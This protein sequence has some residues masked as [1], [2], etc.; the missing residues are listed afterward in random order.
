[1]QKPS[2]IPQPV[3]DSEEDFMN[4]S[5]DK[6]YKPRVSARAKR[7]RVVTP[8]V[9]AAV[10]WAKISS[11]KAV[12]VIGSALIS[13]GHDLNDCALSRMTMHRGRNKARPQIVEALK[14]GMKRDAPLIIHFDGKLLPN[15]S[16]R[17]K[18]ERVAVLVSGG[19]VCLLFI[20]VKISL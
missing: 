17:E 19:T 18:V 2:S 20:D 9:V 14:A 13:A 15:L 5:N 11:R 8:L 3:S 6:D 10:D 1:M 12:G 7:N 4:D 16:G